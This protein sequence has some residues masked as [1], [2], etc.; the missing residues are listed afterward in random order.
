MFMQFSDFIVVSTTAFQCAGS[1]TCNLL[2]PKLV[3]LIA[4]VIWFLHSVFA[5]F[6]I[7][8]IALTYFDFL[9]LSSETFAT[10]AFNQS[11]ANSLHALLLITA[12]TTAW[13]LLLL[14]S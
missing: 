12:G 10:I 11:S 9:A 13:S 4:E 2:L 3:L 5:I 14:V 8:S 7:C 6:A 1:G